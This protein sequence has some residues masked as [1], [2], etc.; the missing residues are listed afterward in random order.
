MIWL[1]FSLAIAAAY[2][3]VGLL[4]AIVRIS[5]HDMPWQLFA[6]T[7]IFWPSLWLG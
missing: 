4:V 1:Q 5:V 3:L 7:I 2:L 6:F